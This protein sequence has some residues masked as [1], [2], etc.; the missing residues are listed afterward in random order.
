VTSGSAGVG[1]G[2]GGV[3]V[4]AG[5]VGGGVAADVVASAVGVVVA[6][7]SP[8]AANIRSPAIRRSANAQGSLNLYAMV[9]ILQEIR[10]V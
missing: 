1:E 7:S 10:G 8:Q 4:A 2:A 3:D 9:P 6:S 5:A